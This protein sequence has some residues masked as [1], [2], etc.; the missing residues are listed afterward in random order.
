MN[1][2]LIYCLKILDSV[3]LTLW[4]KGDTNYNELD[5]D[6]E[7]IN[8]AILIPWSKLESKLDPNPERMN[9]V[10]LITWPI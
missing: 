9:T 7:K 2:L 3:I 10:T 5:S 1:E 6:P 8:T 4:P